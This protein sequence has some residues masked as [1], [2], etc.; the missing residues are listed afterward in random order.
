MLAHTWL[1]WLPP[2]HQKQIIHCSP[3]YRPYTF[4]GEDAPNFPELWDSSYK[5]AFWDLAPTEQHLQPPPCQSLSGALLDRKQSSVRQSSLDPP[6]RVLLWKQQK[7]TSN[8]ADSPLTAPGR[9]SKDS[10][11]AQLQC[12]SFSSLRQSNL[13]LDCIG[14]LSAANADSKHT[15]QPLQAYTGG[16]L[17]SASRAAL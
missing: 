4:A 9:A 3:H 6:K 10:I 15:F 2:H 7:E 8:T 17:Q 5:V 12:S 13:A 16:E 11:R 14:L 1:N